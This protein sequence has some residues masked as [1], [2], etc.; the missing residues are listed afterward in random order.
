MMP[1]REMADTWS[2]WYA[3]S[4]ALRSVVSFAHVGSLIT[5]GGYAIAS[6]LG[7]L[8]AVRR[9]GE[10]VSAELER[11]RTAHRIVI[12]SLVLVIGSGLLLT[13]ADLDAYLA[14]TTF[15]IKMAL[16][17]CLLIN[18]AVLI[19]VTARATVD[20]AR[21][22]RLRL[23]T[24]ASVVLWLATTLLGVVVPNAL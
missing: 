13:L 2:S 16:V 20:H 22:A 3:N 4:A 18:G 12:G 9:G 19:R 23:V 6:D 5:G 17:V 24:T 11:L 15:W 14:S 8:R 21:R 10:S 1:L 7:T